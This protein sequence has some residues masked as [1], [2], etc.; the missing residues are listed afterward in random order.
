M[1]QDTWVQVTEGSLNA[2]STF[3]PGETASSA[4]GNNDWT[5]PRSTPPAKPAAFSTS[6]AQG[7]FGYDFTNKERYFGLHEIAANIRVAV[8]QQ[9]M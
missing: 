3:F 9:P 1:Q 6:T 4:F 8:P 5:R 2:R 7:G